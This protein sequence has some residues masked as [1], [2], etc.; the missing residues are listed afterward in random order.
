MMIL[1]R[2]LN[3]PPPLIPFCRCGHHSD[4]HTQGRDNTRCAECDCMDYENA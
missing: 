2:A 4:Q 1:S 3:E